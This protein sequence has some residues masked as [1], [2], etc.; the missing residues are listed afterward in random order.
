M[1]NFLVAFL[2]VAAASCHF[3]FHNHLFAP[4]HNGR[5]H[6]MPHM[7]G[8]NHNPMAF[9]QQISHI[10]A[11]IEQKMAKFSSP[12]VSEFIIVEE[13]IMSPAA[14]F[15]SKYDVC[16]DKLNVILDNIVNCARLCLNK[17]WQDTIPIMQRTVQLLLEDIKC[18]K[19]ASK[20]AGEG[21]DPQCIIDHLNKAA[22]IV[23]HIF[24][25]LRRFDWQAIQ[26]HVQELVD[27]L[28]D[29]KNC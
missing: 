24:D 16:L 12:R 26:V 15:G 21:I 13:K 19:E 10:Q 28:A 6:H 25:D 7:F 9:F 18:F 1:R 23:A 8:G 3:G 5:R 14:P 29:I 20:K 4:H 2:V 27:T 17:R 11:K 22:D